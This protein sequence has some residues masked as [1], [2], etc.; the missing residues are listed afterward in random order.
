MKQN[1]FTLIELLVV[2]AIIAIL[3][4]ML[5]PA[6]SS[7][8]DRARTASCANNMK[9]ITT[10]L[11]IYCQENDDYVPAANANDSAWLSVINKTNPELLKMEKLLVCPASPSAPREGIEYTHGWG[12]T[13]GMNFTFWGSVSSSTKV[14]SPVR[15]IFHKKAGTALVITETFLQ[16]DMSWDHLERA[17]IG[18]KSTHLYTSYP[19]A[20]HHGKKM[21]TAYAKTYSPAEEKTLQTRDG[22]HAA[23]L[24][25]EVRMLSY[26]LIGDYHNS[27]EY[28]GYDKNN[29]AEDQ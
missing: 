9:Q 21:V 1:L 18:F 25:G 12:T 19:P 24:T 11:I 20:G 13:Y 26:E 5:L 4:A 23:Y 29:L 27:L 10:Y 3:A 28:W 22:I 2:I 6:L 7:A 17:F 8:R 14:W 16:P 15:K